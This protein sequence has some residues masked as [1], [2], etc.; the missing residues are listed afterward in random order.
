MRQILILAVAVL[1][2]GTYF[3]RYADKAVVEA[4]APQ[5]AAVQVSEQPTRK[6]RPVS[7]RWS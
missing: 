4:S 7:T 5:A 3:A 1:A 2:A 6:L